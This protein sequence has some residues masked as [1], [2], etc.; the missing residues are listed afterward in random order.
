[1]ISDSVSGGHDVQV[2]GAAQG[3]PHIVSRPPCLEV[4]FLV[5]CSNSPQVHFDSGVFQTSFVA[6]YDEGQGLWGVPWELQV[7]FGLILEQADLV[8]YRLFGSLTNTLSDIT[9]HK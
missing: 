1:M 6:Q 4:L 7:H 5:E 8:G 9:S 2:H 3:H